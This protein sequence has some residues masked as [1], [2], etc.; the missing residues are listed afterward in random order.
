M[1][2]N[3]QRSPGMESESPQ[4]CWW[5]ALRYGNDEAM[6]VSSTR[7]VV[8]D[9]Q[10]ERTNGGASCS[11][12]CSQASRASL[13]SLES[14]INHSFARPFDACPFSF[15]ESWGWYTRRLG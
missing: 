12:L 6:I 4:Q 2:D 7:C 14:R 8:H 13:S 3:E 5:W 1:P 10:N 11:P 9:V 15:P